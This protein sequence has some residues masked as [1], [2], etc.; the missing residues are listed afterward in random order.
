MRAELELQE[1]I[2]HSPY[3]QIVDWL[4]DEERKGLFKYEEEQLG[5][6]GQVHE[7]EVWP[8]GSKRRFLQRPGTGLPTKLPHKH[9]NEEEREARIRKAERKASGYVP[10]IYQLNVYKI[11]EFDFEPETPKFDE[12]RL[13]NLRASEIT[14][15]AT[16]LTFRAWE[17]YEQ[18]GMG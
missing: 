2:H 7:D 6:N 14:R 12:D 18:R 10:H 8:R 4:S 11:E 1:S 17:A 3:D 16:T 5:L 13:Y 15:K 9:T